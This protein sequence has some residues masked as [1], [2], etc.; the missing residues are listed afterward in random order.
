MKV[1]KITRRELIEMYVTRDSDDEVLNS[2]TENADIGLSKEP[3]IS[4]IF[5]GKEPVM[6]IVVI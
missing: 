6:R 2:V 4:T 3:K 1:V 5:F